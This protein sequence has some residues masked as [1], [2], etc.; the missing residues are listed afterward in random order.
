MLI[1]ILQL[2]YIGI[3]FI[4]FEKHKHGGGKASACNTPALWL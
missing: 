4:S 1:N 3:D 2:I